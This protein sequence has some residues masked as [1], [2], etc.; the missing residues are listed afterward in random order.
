VSVSS[1]RLAPRKE[2]PRVEWSCRSATPGP[3]DE[4]EPALVNPQD[5]KVVT[6]EG[7]DRV[8]GRVCASAT[9][10]KHQRQGQRI[11]PVFLC[12]FELVINNSC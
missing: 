4:S 10:V 8:A 9:V 12:T 3:P 11:G 5:L 6:E 1:P 2:D 7:P